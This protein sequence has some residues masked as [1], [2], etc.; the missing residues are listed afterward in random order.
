[1][2]EHAASP[3]EPGRRRFLTWLTGSVIAVWAASTAAL[4]GLFIGAI[5]HASRAAQAIH[6]F[7]GGQAHK[8]E[9]ALAWEV[10]PIRHQLRS[11]YLTLGRAAPPAAAPAERVRS[12]TAPVELSF[13][14]E[15][16]RLQG[17]RCLRC[18]GET[19]FDGTRCIQCGGCAD[20][21][22]TWC[23]RLVSLDEIGMGGPGSEGMAAII[24]DED[25]CI[26]CGS[27]AERC[28]TD[29]ITMERLCGFESWE[30]VTIG[31]AA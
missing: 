26:R 14:E 11:D 21:C 29:A 3:A 28:P 23:L 17:A 4:T 19:I 2:S 27:C 24:K 13:A 30:P 20:V 5:A 8:V 31:G 12:T 25:R 1:M 10:E 16:A 22:P 6:E 7:L 15:Q 18:E 9:K